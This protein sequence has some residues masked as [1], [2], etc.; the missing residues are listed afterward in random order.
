MKTKRKEMMKIKKMKLTKPSR[1]K[2]KN[3]FFLKEKKLTTIL[4]KK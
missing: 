1:K 3:L 2:K 4:L